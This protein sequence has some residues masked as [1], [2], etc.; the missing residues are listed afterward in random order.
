MLHDAVLHAL[1][2]RTLA[3][4]VRT[5]LGGGW[6]VVEVRA[7]LAPEVVQTWLGTADAEPIRAE[8]ALCD[9]VRHEL[10]GLVAAGTVARRTRRYSAHLRGKGARD[11]VIDL[12][13]LGRGR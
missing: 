12:Y 8:R 11:V 3:E 13:R 10:S 7:R 5:R 4:A 2:P 6:S 1:R 9:A